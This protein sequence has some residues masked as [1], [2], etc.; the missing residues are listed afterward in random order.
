MCLI[1][2]NF[3]YNSYICSRDR[4]YAMRRNDVVEKIRVQTRAM[5]P[6]AQAIIYGSEA[7]GDAR[8]DSDSIY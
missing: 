8:A 4:I 1:V 6:N 7:R 3:N 2:N 5:L